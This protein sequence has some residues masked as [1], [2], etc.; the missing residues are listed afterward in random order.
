MND[1]IRADICVIGGGSAGLTVA[2]GAAQMGAKVV[3]VE[4]D[5]MGG[6][7]LNTGCIPSKALLAAADAAAVMRSAGRFGLG[8]VEPAVDFAAVSRHV[9]D[10]IAQ[11]APH[12]SVERFEGLGVRV[13]RAAARFEAPDTLIA[14]EHVIRAKRFVIATGSRPAIPPIPGLDSAP[15]LT[16]ETIFDLSGKPSHLAVIGGGPVGCE[17]AQAFRRL[18]SKVTLIEQET[19]LPK[20]DPDLTDIVRQH[21]TKEGI[22]VREAARVTR[23]EAVNDGIAL[24]VEQ[25]G[26]SGEFL[27]SH[28][29]VATGRKPNMETL[30]L[31]KALIAA[32][33]RGIAVDQRLRTT[34]K[35][36][37]A[38]GDV[39]GGFQFTHM[40][41]YEGGI[42][43]RNAVF[44]LRAKAAPRAVPWV[45]YTDPELAH[46]GMT[47]Q[48]ARDAGVRF[49]VLSAGFAS[50]DRARTER[51]EDGLI[52][53]LVGAR[54][55][56]LGASIAGRH[57]GEL[58]LPWVLAINEK[59]PI[60]AM[61][62]VIAPYPTLS[63]ISKAV[64]GSYYTP[65][66]YS[67][68]TRWLV[69]LLQKLG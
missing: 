7:C 38:I 62:G 68:R 46:V 42:V 36:I 43:V 66:L 60:R 50:N 21:L 4:K 65:A 12:D 16:N 49:K 39:T 15:Y 18:G 58:I 59:L 5:R 13:I 26:L 64:A 11:I 40:A 67:K 55:R 47:E 2:A 51:A 44:K 14:G 6:D 69:W 28:L 54:G 22:R 61:A 10:V 27:A 33:L 34:N 37:F 9:H 3:L 19:I 23:V 41:G 31:D 52:K 8:A 35:R 24:T 57:A 25:G 17:L 53:V 30:G 1:T 56:I 32:S 63:E 20:D 29:L 45:T 48:A